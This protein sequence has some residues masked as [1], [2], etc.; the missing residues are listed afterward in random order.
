MVD[1]CG[2]SL[3]G[4]VAQRLA[5]DRPDLVREVVV[6]GSGPGTERVSEHVRDLIE[7]AETA[8]HGAG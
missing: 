8:P 4:F 2:T 1:V 6:V 7:R 5:L 3:G